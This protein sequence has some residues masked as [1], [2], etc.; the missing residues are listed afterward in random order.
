MYMLS[1]FCSIFYSILIHINEVISCSASNQK[2]LN[3]KI[4]VIDDTAHFFFY[5][6][7]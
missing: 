6:N 3:Q 2:Q 5:K 4:E 1:Y 7:I